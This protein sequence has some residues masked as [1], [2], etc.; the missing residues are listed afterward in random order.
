MDKIAPNFEKWRTYLKGLTLEIWQ[1]ITPKF[2][3]WEKCRKNLQKW[4]KSRKILKKG[5]NPAKF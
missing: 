2:L 5:Q 4:A 1:K 3:K